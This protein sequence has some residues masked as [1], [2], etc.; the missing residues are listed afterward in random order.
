[1]NP[2]F[3]TLDSVLDG[4]E[5]RLQGRARQL[6]RVAH[7]TPPIPTTDHD[8]MAWIDGQEECG[9]TGHGRTE[10]EALLELCERLEQSAALTRITNGLP[11]DYTEDEF[12]AYSALTLAREMAL[13][14]AP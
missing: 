4:V 12:R 7:I 10:A 6:V 5:S 1:M 3:K 13:K 11:A 14:A 9:P 8:W 2:L